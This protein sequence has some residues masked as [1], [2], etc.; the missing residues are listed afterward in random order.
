MKRRRARVE[1]SPATV[2]LGLRGEFL[3]HLRQV[4]PGLA[5]KETLTLAVDAVRQAERAGLTD[6]GGWQAEHVRAVADTWPDDDHLPRSVVALLIGFL[7]A[8]GRW[9]GEVAALDELGMGLRQ[10]M[11]GLLR[12]AAAEHHDPAAEADAVRACD[13][14]ARQSALLRWMG[15]NTRPVTGTRA[16]RKADS[17]AVIELLGLPEQKFTSMWDHPGLADL[18]STARR[19]GLV[20]VDG[21]RAGVTA[22]GLA[23]AHGDAQQ[24]RALVAFDLARGLL[25]PDDVPD[26]G[27]PIEAVAG[28]AWDLVQGRDVEVPDEVLDLDPMDLLLLNSSLGAHLVADAEEESLGVALL[29]RALTATEGFAVDR[30]HLRLMPGLESLVLG[31]LADLIDGHPLAEGGTLLGVARARQGVVRV[32]P[33]ELAGSTLRLHTVLDAHSPEEHLVEVAADST[34]ADL[35]RVL[36]TAF[37]LPDAQHEFTGSSPVGQDRCWTDHRADTHGIDDTSVT[38]LDLVSWA[39]RLAYEHGAP[40]G[41]FGHGATAVHIEVDGVVPT[42]GR[43]PLVDG[44]PPWPR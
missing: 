28:I 14:V 27:L 8:T 10:N 11:A 23:L 12:R 41:F 7:E 20:V 31:T 19:A 3:Q 13:V 39:G 21:G 30:G 16:L 15:P 42:T 43:L 5:A 18:W 2:L 26:V 33:D 17:R 24:A 37:D 9:H 44:R 32:R 25:E 40:T 1:K 35:H 22:T 29:L 34:P 4:A 36:L 38:V 6:L